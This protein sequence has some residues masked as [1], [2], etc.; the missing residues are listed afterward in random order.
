[1]KIIKIIPENYFEHSFFD[2]MTNY[3]EEEGK[4]LD[5]TIYFSNN[6][7]EI[8]EDGKNIIAI[9]TAGDER[10]NPPAYSHKIK[11]VFKH[12]LNKENI[13]NVFHLPLPP[14]NGFF[15]K[16]KN[17]WEERDIDVFF[18]GHCIDPRGKPIPTRINFY[19]N[20]NN[21][22]SSFTN[23]NIVIKITDKWNSG[24]N[25]KEYSDTMSRSKIILSPHGH[26]RPECIRFTEGI[27]AGCAVIACNQPATDSYKETPFISLNNDKWD[28]AIK[29]IKMILGFKNVWNNFH[30]GSLEAWNKI[31]SAEAQAK[32]II[33]ILRKNN[34]NKSGK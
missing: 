14:M 22:K 2:Q 5:Y 19:K 3:I 21:I 9:L 8:P 24:M 7:K 34:D 26:H 15:P 28:Q 33:Q 30:K 16:S 10:G 29:H 12:H 4:D 18:S 1:M 31:Y 17:T 25:I 20:I 13:N 11:Y 32:K 27:M 23:K 6:Y